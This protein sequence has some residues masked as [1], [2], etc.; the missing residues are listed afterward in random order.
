MRRTPKLGQHFLKH[1]WA[2][3]KLAHAAGL[4]AEETFVEVGPGKG[5]LTREL[6]LLGPVVAIEKD[7]DLVHSLHETFAPE[8]A[9][10]KL[11][12]IEGDVRDFDARSIHM[13]YTLAANIPYYITGEILRAFLSSA[14]QPRVA[15]L[16]VQKEVADR[17]V[18]KKE[19]ILSL[20]VKAYGVPHIRGRVPARHFSPPPRVDSAILVID[21]I[22]RAFF[23]DID[24]AT[25]FTVV[26]I[27]FASKRKQLANNLG[28]KFAR[29]RVL[30]ALS[31][32]DIDPKAR[33]EDVPLE[34]WKGLA[35]QLY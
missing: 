5:V 33:A 15:A 8:I 2:A 18:S 24:E 19:S 32:C 4:R 26:H 9:S 17:I 25:F 21:N 12:L 14:H 29:D 11:R 13:P 30:A 6:L 28:T 27:G 1:R 35:M 3:T 34:K 16:L 10:G 22:S 23:D 20:S 7:R 31:A